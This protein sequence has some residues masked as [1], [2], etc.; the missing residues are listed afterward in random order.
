MKKNVLFVFILVLLQFGGCSYN[1]KANVSN[2]SQSEAANEEIDI[3]VSPTPVP[4]VTAT[5][6]PLP[7]KKINIEDN[8][9]LNNITDLSKSPRRFDTEGEQSAS[10]TLN[11]PAPHS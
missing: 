3:T 1:D 9:L 10:G 5:I 2:K 8:E 7:V 4:P 11:S 6:T